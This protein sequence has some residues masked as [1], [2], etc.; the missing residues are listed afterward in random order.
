MVT[1]PSPLVT[2]HRRA[3]YCELTRATFGSFDD[4]LITVTAS[5]SATPQDERP[6]STGAPKSKRR[7]W[8][9]PTGYSAG[10]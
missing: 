4:L 1:A 5:C 8:L 7:R 6:N 3:R 10:G 9:L 2:V